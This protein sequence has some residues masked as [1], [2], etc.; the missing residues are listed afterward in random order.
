MVHKLIIARRRE[1]A[2]R[3]WKKEKDLQQ[4]TALAKIVRV[5]EVQRVLRE[6]RMS[7]D[8]RNDIR[9]SCAEADLNMTALGLVWP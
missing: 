7:K 8:V 4:C 6:K 9:M 1:G 5:E 2:D 3:E